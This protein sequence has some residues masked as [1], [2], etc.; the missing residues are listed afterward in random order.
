[1]ADQQPQDQPQPASGNSGQDWTDVSAQDIEQKLSNAADLAYELAGN[2]G[3]TRDE[4]KFRDT[5]ELESIETAL[6]V[7][8]KQLDHLVGK[9]KEELGVVPSTG[10]NSQPSVPS[11]PDFMSEF[12]S[13]EPVAV[14]PEPFATAEASAQSAVATHGRNSESASHSH[15]TAASS[16]PGLIGVGTLGT[17]ENEVSHR[18]QEP[19]ADTAEKPARQPMWARVLEGPAYQVCNIAIFVLEAI[20][21]PLARLGSKTRRALSV[22]AI[23]AFCVCLAIFVLS[24]LFS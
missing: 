21:R 1:M 12:L 10:A 6:D 5:S 4:P 17:R 18:P 16:K 13:D 7:E 19:R 22:T 24:L 3:V 8:L 14:V 9:A 20:D 15:P 2:V 23:A 11:I